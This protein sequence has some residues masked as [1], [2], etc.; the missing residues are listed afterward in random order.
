MK[1]RVGKREE[2][3]EKKIE[4]I[5]LRGATVI[6]EEERRSL[7]G[8]ID[9]VQE[10]EIDRVNIPNTNTDALEADLEIGIIDPSV[11]ITNI[12]LQLLYA[13]PCTLTVSVLPSVKIEK[14]RLMS[15]SPDHMD[16]V[17]SFGGVAAC[18]KEKFP[19]Y[20]K[21]SPASNNGRQGA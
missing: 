11:S 2:I 19:S 8:G 21:L 10:V 15:S 6:R 14:K 3:K 17:C 16:T 4:A 1:V 20:F 12:A 5:A 7:L 9:L 18:C 13:N